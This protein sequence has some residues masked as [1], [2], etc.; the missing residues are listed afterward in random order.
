MGL[1]EKRGIGVFYLAC[2]CKVDDTNLP[3]PLLLRRPGP[4]PGRVWSW[5]RSLK[6]LY[7]LRPIPDSAR[8]RNPWH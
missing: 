7:V 2:E 6:S 3:Q 5:C 1:R 4:L 8:F